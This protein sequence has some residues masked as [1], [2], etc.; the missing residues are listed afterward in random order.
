MASIINKMV[1]WAAREAEERASKF[2]IPLEQAAEEVADKYGQKVFGLSQKEGIPDFPTD[3]T[4]FLGKRSETENKSLRELISPGV[5]ESI[6]AREA[7]KYA[8]PGPLNRPVSGAGEKAMLGVQESTMAREASRY[9]EPD[10]PQYGP[11]YQGRQRGF[12]PTYR[13]PGAGWKAGLAAGGAGAAALAGGLAL[14]DK[15]RGSTADSESGREQWKAKKA[16]QLSR[17]QIPFTDEDLER[18]WQATQESKT[19]AAKSSLSASLQ[20]GAEGMGKREEQLQTLR[21]FQKEQGIPEEQLS[22]LPRPATPK[23]LEEEQLARF[24]ATRQAEEANAPSVPESTIP[25]PTETKP[26]AEVEPTKPAAPA[27]VKAAVG[28]PKAPEDKTET[29]LKASTER[30][31]SLMDDLANLSYE[32]PRDQAAIQAQ[33][34]RAYELYDKAETRNDWLQVAETLAQALAQFGAAQAGMRS[35][36]AMVLPQMPRTDYGARTARAERR[37]ERELRTIEQDEEA[38]ERAAKETRGV[39]EFKIR[40][41]L[42]KEKISS[43]ELRERLKEKAR[44]EEK[45]AERAERA[46]RPEKIDP[47]TQY[48]YKQEY[49]AAAKEAKS[50]DEQLQKAQ[51]AASL[52]TPSLDS[53]TL[54]KQI[55]SNKGAFQEAGVSIDEVNNII[56]SLESSKWFESD[57]EAAERIQRNKQKVQDAIVEP[58]RQKRDAATQQAKTLLE[59]FQQMQSG[60]QPVRPAAQPTGQPA[61]S[62]GTVKIQAPD[63]TIA[64]VPADKAQKYIDKGGK[65]VQ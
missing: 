42:E 35:G 39:E 46:G 40:S 13:E 52:I 12:D 61:A 5:E 47:M 57:K 10:L 56:D 54:K 48:A 18:Q 9:R 15:E 30:R 63:G 49:S 53:Q 50:A 36:Q 31:L 62:S 23:E 16:A 1:S 21:G 25:P 64:E 34:D 33:R 27:T 37:L 26:A 59:S 60:R 14:R 43:E 55:Q 17:M 8:E 4:R 32:N 2:G 45:A 51:K 38:K 11:E 3:P 65:I 29:E 41:Q 24:Y 20:R 7:S 6:S 22:K 58:I 28:K 19:A 44:A